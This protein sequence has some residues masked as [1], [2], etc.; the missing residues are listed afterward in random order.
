VGPAARQCV[1]TNRDFDAEL[2]AHAYAVL[3]QETLEL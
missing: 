3:E 2:K 1:Q